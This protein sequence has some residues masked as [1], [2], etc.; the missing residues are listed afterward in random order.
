M[1]QCQLSNNRWINFWKLGIKNIYWVPVN[2][3]TE[4]GNKA[5]FW[6]KIKGTT[7]KVFSYLHVCKINKINDLFW[8]HVCK[9]LPYGLEIAYIVFRKKRSILFISI[10]I[11]S[12]INN[13]YYFTMIIVIK[14]LL[15]INKI[16]V[17]NKVK[18]L[19]RL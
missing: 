1:K 3:Q 8:L 2:Y 9:K 11:I 15:F 16:V 7:F 19:Y 5:V 18:Q 13:R 10:K 4:L 17:T 6:V 12:F 14:T